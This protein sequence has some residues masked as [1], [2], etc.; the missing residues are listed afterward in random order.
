MA[1]FLHQI[2]ALPTVVYTAL[3]GIVF[4]YWLFVIVGA[5][6]IDMVGG[7]VEGLAE[8]AAEGG[9]EG[10]AEG[11][12]EGATEGAMEGSRG[13]H[14]RRAEGVMEGAAEGVMEGAAEGV[15]E[16]AAEGVM[17]GAAE[18]VMEGAAEGAMEGAAEGAM[19][20]AAEGGL[21]GVTEG[22]A[23]GAVETAA[24]GLGG[25][26][27]GAAGTSGGSA[28]GLSDGLS[29][30]SFMTWLGLRNAPF[31][32]VFSLIILL[33]WTA[34]FLGMRY[35]APTLGN[36]GLASGL[37]ALGALV[38]ATPITGF[39]ARPLGPLFHVRAAEGRRDLV[40]HTCV[41]ETGTVDE[42]F[43]VATVHEGGRWPR[44]EVRAATPNTI[45][46]GSEVLI[47][48]YDAVDETFRVESIGP[49]DSARS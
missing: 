5:L 16:G 12:M 19:E 33:A 40:G 1:Q 30:M 48:R 15:M 39:M 44:V 36:G 42:N 45:R 35:V 2:M 14:G 32:V 41:V 20:G 47:V 26:A 37:V 13:R 17:E 43:G 8:G 10:A 6:D 34:C 27:E 3:L 7:D 24:E 46:R 18:G 21:E 29:L 31:T 25:S 11:A 23:E 28:S 4:V 38:L 9:F 22:T 49:D